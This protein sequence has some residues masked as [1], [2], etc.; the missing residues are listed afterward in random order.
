MPPCWMLKVEGTKTYPYRVTARNLCRLLMV[1][2]YLQFQALSRIRFQRRLELCKLTPL[3]WEEY[4]HL[5]AK[6]YTHKLHPSALNK[7]PHAG[8]TRQLQAPLRIMGRYQR[9]LGG[10]SYD[11]ILQF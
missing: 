6:L 1:F 9:G 8:N 10:K 3:M 2:R 11:V 4:F 7:N 5:L